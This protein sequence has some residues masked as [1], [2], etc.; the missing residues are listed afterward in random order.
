MPPTDISPTARAAILTVSDSVFAG[1]RI[2]RSGPAV[3]EFLRQNGWTTV[4][5][6]IVADDLAVIAATLR[7]LCSHGV[8]VVF[9]VG[10]T[11][12]SSRDVTPEATRKVITREIPGLTEQMRRE[13]F[14]SAPTAILS[15]SVAGLSGSSLIINLPGNPQGAVDSLKAI[16][17]VLPHAV[18]LVAG[19]TDHPG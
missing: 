3:A 4:E 17:P 19:K 1:Q 16:F 5:N 9:T 10:G 18:D 2:D 12:L 11:G 13:G 7:E 8:A 6:R 14:R 15:R